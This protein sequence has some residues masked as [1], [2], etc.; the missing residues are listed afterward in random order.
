MR[1]VSRVGPD[2]H[3]PEAG[4][5]KTP[6]ADGCPDVWQLDNGDYAVIGIHVDAQVEKPL[7]PTASCGPDETIVMVPKKIFE[8]AAR[9]LSD[10]T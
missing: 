3:S 7:P 5:P 10:A 4:G 6:A 9:D 1:L 8:A 2:P